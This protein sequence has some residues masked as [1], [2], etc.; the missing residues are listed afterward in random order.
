MEP[1]RSYVID[2]PH[3]RFSFEVEEETVGLPPFDVECP[4]CGKT[5][6][7]EFIQEIIE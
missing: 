6:G 4:N 2:C 5:V 1:R 3:C 7:S